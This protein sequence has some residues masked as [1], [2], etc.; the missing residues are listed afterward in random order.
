M[1]NPF[2]KK[3]LI[4][5]CIIFIAYNAGIFFFRK[6]TREEQI[7]KALNYDLKF[8]EQN[9]PPSALGQSSPNRSPT[10]AIRKK[11]D[12]LPV[13][14]NVSKT[15]KDDFINSLKNARSEKVFISQNQ[16]QWAIKPDFFAL[17]NPPEDIQELALTNFANTYFYSQS[18]K[19][20]NTEKE[21]PK[22]E[23]KIVVFDEVNQ[24]VGVMSGLLLIKLSREKYPSE[25]D[26]S[27]YLKTLLQNYQL[28]IVQ[29]FPHLGR[30]SLA[31]IEPLSSPKEFQD[32]MLL[33]KNQD[34]DQSLDEIE[35]EIIYRFV[36][37]K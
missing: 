37:K 33:L 12:P 21:L 17:I 34:Q 11:E 9:N 14:E 1:K 36:E 5:S 16:F 3:I 28:K 26:Q 8:S 20:I 31:P 13:L 10:Q 6:P 22:V 7:M 2:L 30:Y 24:L 29:Q 25:L 19:L 32:L 27:Q 23:K 35:W 15:S 4:F 18:I